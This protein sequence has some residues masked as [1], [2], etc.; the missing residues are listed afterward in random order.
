MK[1]VLFID[2]MKPDDT[3][4]VAE[5]WA[6]HDKTGLPQEIGVVGR[7]L[8]SFRGLYVHLVEGH[9]DLPG[10]LTERIYAARTNPLFIETRDSLARYLTPYSGALTNL[11][12]TKAEEFYRWQA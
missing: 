6:A 9:A 4:N 8:F 12:D 11:K 7:T 2:R 1:R 10:D 3:D 5:I